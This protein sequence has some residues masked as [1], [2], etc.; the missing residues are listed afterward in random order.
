MAFRFEHYE[1]SQHRKQQ[2]AALQQQYHVL[3]AINRRLE[4][5]EARQGEGQDITSQVVETKVER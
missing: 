1:A 2:E 3:K 5:L 4:L